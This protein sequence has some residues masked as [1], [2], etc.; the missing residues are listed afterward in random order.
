MCLEAICPSPVTGNALQR[1]PRLCAVVS[2]LWCL[3]CGVCV[4]VWLQGDVA[5]L[6]LQPAKAVK[7]AFIALVR[8]AE[9]ATGDLRTADQV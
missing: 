9:C 2:V 3:C 1:T 4:V 8:H 7:D 5:L 6:A